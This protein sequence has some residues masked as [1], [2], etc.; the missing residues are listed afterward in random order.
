MPTPDELE[1]MLP[2]L[3]SKCFRFAHKRADLFGGWC[4]PKCEQWDVAG[5]KRSGSQH[6]ECCQGIEH[7][8]WATW[9]KSPKLH[10]PED[11]RD[12]QEWDELRETLRDAQIASGCAQRKRDSDARKLAKA[13]SVPLM[14][15]AAAQPARSPLIP[16]VAHFKQQQQ[17]EASREA[18]EPL[19]PGEYGESDA[20]N[21]RAKLAA[22]EQDRAKAAKLAALEQDRAKLAALEQDRAKLMTRMRAPELAFIVPAPEVTPIRTPK[23]KGPQP[24]SLPPT[25]TQRAAQYRHRAQSPEAERPPAPMC[26]SCGMFKAAQDMLCMSC[27]NDRDEEQDVRRRVRA[28]R[29]DFLRSPEPKRPRARVDVRSPEPKAM[30]LPEPKW[31]RGPRGRNMGSSAH[32]GRGRDM[33]SSTEPVTEEEKPLEYCPHPCC[34]RWEHQSRDPKFERHCCRLCLE[35]FTNVYSQH[36]CRHWKDT[37]DLSEEDFQVPHGQKCCTVYVT[38][39]PNI[40]QRKREGSYHEDAGRW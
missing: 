25:Q 14:S 21:D 35:H 40:K 8:S 32:G 13:R 39:V 37:R 33:G 30:R 27:L 34:D 26:K 28:G 3:C 9:G 1:T 31:G 24:P 18:C 10:T 11:Q 12:W 20:D 17:L 19:E 38:A 2:C 4:C 15:P 7:P 29:V 22:L 6:G 23:S 5:Y 16:G 36:G